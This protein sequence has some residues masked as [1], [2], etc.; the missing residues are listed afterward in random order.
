M[1]LLLQHRDTVLEALAAHDCVI[2]MGDT[3]CGKTT[4]LPQLLLDAGFDR[5]C[6]TQPRRVAAISAAHRVA[7]VS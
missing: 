4:Q 6:V 7:E 3:G 5:V 2:V 1:S